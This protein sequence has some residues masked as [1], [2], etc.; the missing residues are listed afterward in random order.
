MEGSIWLAVLIV[1]AIGL[2]AGIGLAVA[3]MVFAVKK[4]QKAEE[5]LACLPGANCGGCGYSGCEGYAKAVAAG[6]AAPTL[7]APGGAAAAAAIAKVLGQQ[8]DAAGLVKKVALVRCNGTGE[9]TSDKMQYIGIKSCRAASMQF[10][11]TG[12]CYYGCLGFGDCAV[13]C[14]FHSIRVIDGVARV[15]IDACTGCGAC[16]KACPKA[17]IELIPADAKAAVLCRNADP[18]A[19]TRQVCKAG[20]IGCTKCTR[21]CPTGAAQMQGALAHIEAS[22][23]TGCG[24]CADACPTHAICGASCSQTD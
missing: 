22:L 13:A 11:G 1:G 8:A 7:C 9:N 16:V 15:N 5:V 20:C 19:K 3:S 23:C 21:V 6:K 4:D 18:G 24:A 12:Q 17:L 2:I 10:G 14:S